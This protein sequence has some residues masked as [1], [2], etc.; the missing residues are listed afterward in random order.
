MW[1]P[2]NNTEDGMW[3]KE[4]IEQLGRKKEKTPHP[5]FS[6]GLKLTEQ[7][8]KYDRNLFYIGLKIS[9]HIVSLVSRFAAMKWAAP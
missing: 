9:S 1:N 7:G 4:K 8:A 6:K 2:K 5:I 3:K